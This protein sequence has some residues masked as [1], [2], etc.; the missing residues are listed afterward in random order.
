MT[1]PAFVRQWEGATGGG[2]LS[3]TNEA[4]LTAGDPI[5]SANNIGQ[6][7]LRASGV[8]YATAA[9]N[10][11][12]QRGGNATGYYTIDTGDTSVP[13]AT[14]R[15]RLDGETSTQWRGYIDSIH[16]RYAQPINVSTASVTYP[17]VSSVVALEGGGCGFARV[18]L[19][20]AGASGIQFLYKTSRRGAWSSATI[21][22]STTLAFN[23]GASPGV[24]RLASGRLLCAIHATSGAIATYYSDDDGATWAEWAA[25][26]GLSVGTNARQL[27]LESVEDAVMFVGSMIPGGSTIDAILAW[28]YDGGQTFASVD[29]PTWG[30]TRTVVTA[31][32]VALAA[33]T[34]QST[35]TINVYRLLPGAA[36][37]STAMAGIGG[38]HATNSVLEIALRDDGVL[39]GLSAGAFYPAPQII[40]LTS[41]DHG[42]T[43][44]DPAAQS[45]GATVWSN[46][47]DTSTPRGLRQL[48]AG[49]LDGT[50]VV[51]GVSD[52]STATY[53]NSNHE[54]QFGG[55]DSL[56]EGRQALG[57]VEPYNAGTLLGTDTFAALDWTATD[58]GTGATLTVDDNGITIDGDA[59]NN[60]YYT[61][62][63]TFFAAGTYTNGWR[64]RALFN[65]T[66][67]GSVADNRAVIAI[68][69]A[70]GAGKVIGTYLRISTSQI[71]LVDQAGTTL[72]SSSIVASQ[73]TVDT[74]FLCALDATYSSTEGIA[75]AWYR[76]A[77]QTHWTNLADGVI[78]TKTTAAVTLPRVGAVDTAAAVWTLKQLSM[79][80]DELGL[81]AGFTNPT[82]LSGRPLTAAYDFCIENGVRVGAAG[83][84]GVAADSYDLATDASFSRQWVWKSLRPSVEHRSTADNADHAIVFDAAANNVIAAQFV[85]LIG[86][87]FRTAVFAMHTANSW[88]SPSVSVNLDATLYQGTVS[89]SKRGLSYVGV[90]GDPWVPHQWRS[91]AGRRIYASI[92]GVVYEVADNDA[93]VI[94]IAGTDFSAASGTI[95][96]FGDRMGAVLSGGVQRYR[97]ARAFV[98]AQQTSD[99]FYRVGTVITGLVTELT[100][101]YAQGFVWTYP[102]NTAE[103]EAE[104]GFVTTRVAGPMRP[105]LRMAWDP[106]SVPESDQLRKMEHLWRAIRG[107][108]EPVV[109]G[110]DLLNRP[111]LFDLYHVTGPFAVENVTGEL[112]N[113]LSRISQIILRKVI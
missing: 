104:G 82:N 44:Y 3:A 35:T 88:A 15:Y 52:G 59:T 112:D 24:C 81:S 72:A 51:V 26:V 83:G 66:S 106:V 79:S 21:V 65:I 20:S 42:L 92:G 25:D 61:A 85:G 77:G 28:S 67:G 23:T 50:L 107:R 109:F 16:L 47:T 89:T 105:E 74:E 100:D 38:A 45:S 94:Y 39:V 93:G 8:P 31:T 95:Y 33:A 10:F 102:D 14:L 29:T 108:H 5:A 13:G 91:E 69:S 37:P 99:D 86:T 63:A 113:D 54:F 62:P 36:A 53:D 9:Y 110:P 101:P 73:F 40:M 68:E 41:R 111:N 32:G 11:A 55:W 60:S 90:D 17:G 34:N 76:L 98:A 22:S 19:P 78:I 49:M 48:G 27:S 96:I 64:W 58:A 18:R 71:R 46:G 103:A 87:N 2:V 6:M 12:L 97:Y 56:T 75:S 7:R 84:G 57:A 70:D 80:P 30:P 1:R 43:W 4:G